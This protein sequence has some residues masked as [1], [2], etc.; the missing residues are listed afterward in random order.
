[1]VS[2]TVVVADQDEIFCEGFATVL[3]RS[4]RYQVLASAHDDASLIEAIRAHRPRMVILD[5]RLAVAGVDQV[6]AA[7]PSA[8]I[9][10]MSPERAPARPA[11]PA[12]GILSKSQD[13]RSMME[14]LDLIA[15]NRP[16]VI[17]EIGRK[18]PRVNR[19]PIPGPQALAKLSPR[20]R[21]VLEFVAASYTSKEI[22]E[23]LGI[24]Q[25][26]VEVHRHHMLKKLGVRGV[27]DL[28]KFAIRAGITEI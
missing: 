25:R 8:R 7:I 22:A 3:A 9:I 12:A 5:Q 1:M 14:A 4:G 13:A 26:T 16:V 28:M 21:Q 19:H 27:A 6:Q 23:T 15:D 2:N 10:L 18:R 24:T 20:E 11:A 17:D